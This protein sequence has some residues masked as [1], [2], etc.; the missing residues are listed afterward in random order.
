MARLLPLLSLLLLS[1]ST[2]AA[3]TTASGSMILHERIL[4]PRSWQPLARAPPAHTLRLRISLSQPR[5]PELH[6]ALLAVSDPGHELYGQHLSK[7]EVEA[8]ARPRE[9][10][11]SAVERWLADAGVDLGKVER[12]PAGDTLILTVP[13]SMAEAL[14]GAEYHL[15]SHRST[16]EHIVRTTAF[17][18]PAEVHPHVR[19]VQPTTLFAR[20]RALRSPVRALQPLADA[21]FDGAEGAASA[22]SS[23]KTSVTPA[24]LESL[25]A[26]TGYTASA[27]ATMLGITGYLEQY[28]NA[29]DLQSFY[30]GYAESAV[31]STFQT[32]LVNGG[33]N[34]QTLS[35]AGTE[36]NLDT[37]Y[38][39]ALTYPVPNVFYSTGGS[40][41]FNPDDAEDSNTNEPYAEWLD[42]VLALDS[43]DLPSVV[44]TSYGDDEQT[45]PE[46]YA[47]AVCD[48]F[49]QL[50]ARG[51]SVI[52]ASGDSG[53]GPSA[54]ECYSN[55]G[56]D[57]QMFIPNF[58][59]SCP[60][61]TTVG[62]TTSTGPE[63]AASFSG[64][65]FSNYFAQPSYQASAVASFLSTLGN[66]Y[67][68]LYN[69]S[70]RA[71][72]DVSAQGENFIIYVSGAP[73][74]VDGTSCSTP[75][76]AS[77]ITLVNDALVRAG[78]APLGFLNPFLYGAGLGGL[79]DVTEGSNPGCGTKGFEAGEGWDPVTGLGTPV[80]TT[81][82]TLAGA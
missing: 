28:A 17:S 64:G 61:V 53:V 57:T 27:N 32:V 10:A 23:C 7:G 41:P 18:L 74:Q 25:Y 59:A 9:E 1:L 24:C 60:Y 71:Y 49:A 30:K 38:G 8:L 51:V 11:V 42:Y 58:P 15:F 4:T 66:E 65:G 46:S 67:S 77:V 44:S 52:F 54:D 20:P 3:P 40:P 73:G 48:Q 80:F 43:D 55:D 26:T 29:Q 2:L 62:A 5:M 12:S 31:G 22:A 21:V 34:D 6:T 70:G 72:P 68:G 36:A 69:A 35:A 47:L 45:V 78:K 16:G 75:T 14:L 63:I 82:R 79:T 19:T 56:T 13:V 39:G 81:L 76:F 50:G 33:E 37:Q